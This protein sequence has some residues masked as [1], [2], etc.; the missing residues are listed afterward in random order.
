MGLI[1][2]STKVEAKKHVDF[3]DARYQSADKLIQNKKSMRS[4][5]TLYDS[6]DVNKVAVQDI[7]AAYA[8]SDKKMPVGELLNKM[9]DLTIDM[10]DGVLDTEKDAIYAWK[11][12]V[13]LL[14][15]HKDKVKRQDTLS[16]FDNG[17]KNSIINSKVF[18]SR[19]PGKYTSRTN[20]FDQKIKLGMA[21][22]IVDTFKEAALPKIH[23]A[24]IEQ[25]RRIAKEHNNPILDRIVNWAI[26]NYECKADSFFEVQEDQ[27]TNL[28]YSKNTII[29][30]LKNGYDMSIV[31]YV[32]TEH[33]DLFALSVLDANKIELKEHDE[34]VSQQNLQDVLTNTAENDPVNPLIKLLEAEKKK[35]SIL[36]QQYDILVDT[37]PMIPADVL[38]LV[39]AEDVVGRDYIW[40]CEKF[41][42][43]HEDLPRD[44]KLEDV[45]LPKIED[46]LLDESEALIDELSEIADTVVKNQTD[47]TQDVETGQADNL[48]A[49]TAEEFLA[50]TQKPDMLFAENEKETEEDQHEFGNDNRAD[51]NMP[52]LSLAGEPAKTIGTEKKDEQLF[53]SSNTLLPGF[54]PKKEE[55]QDIGPSVTQQAQP[56]SEATNLDDL[57]KDTD[58]VILPEVKNQEYAAED[59]VQQP[60]LL[61]DNLDSLFE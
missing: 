60:D 13:A 16:V 18:Q 27:N 11:Y 50:N 36:K 37:R 49:E 17:L 28:L 5:F 59:N 30:H 32:G 47:D 24:A 48:F 34:R 8:L 42:E 1:D 40:G 38:R 20:F 43:S 35:N 6:K 7:S 3:N 54:V 4:A 39:V 31:G 26:E 55:P 2:L 45:E 25:S 56:I 22:D 9:V 44:F 46:D 53:D 12:S 29:L 57:W 41:R 19:Y 61:L 23:E 52:I 14:E 15:M 33:D 10:E 51:F 58:E 21:Q